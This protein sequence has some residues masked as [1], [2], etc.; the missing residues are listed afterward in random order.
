M[1]RHGWKKAEIELLRVLV[2]QKNNKDIAIQFNCTVNDV[3]SALHKYK[4]KRSPEASKSVRVRAKEK[5]HNWKGGVSDYEH[6][7]IQRQRFPEKVKAR[8]AVQKA[9]KKGV[10]VK[11]TRCEVCGETKPLHGHHESYELSMRL[12]VV[13]CCREC[14]RKIHGGTH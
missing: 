2:E 6:T 8:D 14:H 9:L 4:I 11:P 1:R 7:K 12:V 3:V 13:W 10:L 5:H